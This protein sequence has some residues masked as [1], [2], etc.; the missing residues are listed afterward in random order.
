M[1]G[2]TT[3]ITATVRTL[4]VVPLPIPYFLSFVQYRLPQPTKLSVLP[5]GSSCPVAATVLAKNQA[6][7]TTV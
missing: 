7:Q 6:T 3:G 4:H 1:A 2:V 5:R